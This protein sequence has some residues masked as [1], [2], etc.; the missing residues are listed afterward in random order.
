[1]SRSKTSSSSFS[2]FHTMPLGIIKIFSVL[3]LFTLE[4]SINL[5]SESLN[6][7][8]S[9]R[10]I[11]VLHLYT[12][13]IYLLVLQ[14]LSN[15]FIITEKSSPEKC[16]FDHIT[17]N[18]QC[19]WWFSMTLLQC[20]FLAFFAGWGIYG[21][22]N[23]PCCDVLDELQLTQVFQTNTVRWVNQERNISHKLAIFFICWF[24][25]KCTVP[26]YKWKK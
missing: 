16:I 7:W 26:I 1:M 11:P 17:L 14:Y 24:I 9:F 6:L 10:L 19:W 20:Y 4:V 18:F 8:M 5:K 13:L 3:Q 15:F 23:K 2:V 21:K 25:D 12:C 22:A